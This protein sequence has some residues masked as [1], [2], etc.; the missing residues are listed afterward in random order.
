MKRFS[1]FVVGL[2]DDYS[3]ARHRVHPDGR[4]HLIQLVRQ[5]VSKLLHELGRLPKRGD[6]IKAGGYTIRV[7]SVRENRIVAL[8][9]H[10]G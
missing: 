2:H 3:P 1:G 7:E 6:S 9:I 4:F 10:P 5:Q 8:R